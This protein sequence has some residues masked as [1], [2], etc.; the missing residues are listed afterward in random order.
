MIKNRFFFAIAGVLALVTLYFV[1]DRLLF[2]AHAEKTTGTVT[3]VDASNGRCGGSKR[4][5]SY[6]CTKFHAD[7]EF[8]A[9]DQSHTFSV[10][11][12]D[13]RG[14]DQPVSRARHQVGDAVAVVYNPDRPDEAYR[15]NWFDIWSTPLFAA[16]GHLIAL[17]GSMKERR[18]EENP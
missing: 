8:A 17:F 1:T 6:D 7:I 13:A 18:R 14:H 12:G 4:R 2:I 5:R 9:T 11:A 15:D 3:A 16:F 10:S